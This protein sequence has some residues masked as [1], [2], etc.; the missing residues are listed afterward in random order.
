MKSYFKLSLAIFVLVITGCE[1]RY[2]GKKE[3]TDHIKGE[4]LAVDMLMGNSFIGMKDDMLAM[5]SYDKDSM[6]VVYRIC[7]DSLHCERHFGV[8]G[9][10]PFEFD[11]AVFS[12]EVD[13]LYVIDEV[14]FGGELMSMR[15]IDFRHPDRAYD[16]RLWKEDDLQ[17]MNPFH[18]G[19]GFVSLGGQKFL[20]LGSR[21]DTEE[22]LTK[23]DI[24]KKETH[25]LGY[26]IEDDYEGPVLPKQSAYLSNSKLHKHGNRILFACGEGRYLELFDIEG[27]SIAR[28]IPIYDI[29]PDYEAAE[30]KLNYAMHYENLR[31][32]RVCTTDRYIYVHLNVYTHE[33]KPYKGY[34]FYYFDELEVYDWDGRFICNYQTDVPFC[35]M[36]VS[37]NDETIYVYTQDIETKEPVIMRYSLNH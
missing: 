21:Y 28:R 32:M 19:D 26:W 30:D 12:Q 6:A 3:V 18:F 2:I 27:D 9:R 17:W 33:M 13:S 37:E 29:R 15:S 4:V 23:V 36:I 25:P 24:G 1:T 7:G 11:M 22:L 10:G 16:Y 8:K 35:D 5:K 31:G 20:F 34:P 14:Q